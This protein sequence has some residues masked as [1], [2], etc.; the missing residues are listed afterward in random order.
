[1]APP[2][3]P[4]DGAV[5]ETIRTR[6]GTHPLIESVRTDRTGGTISTVCAKL[7][8]DRYPARIQDAEL[9][10]R[11]YTNSDYNFHYL[12]T[13]DAAVWQ[14]RWDRHLNP[15]TQRTHFHPPPEASSADA[16]PDSPGDQHP[17]AIFTRTL[18]NIRERIDDLWEETEL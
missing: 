18:A 11:W 6:A 14:C 16:I 3:A 17:Q 4:I 5:L 2:S 15:H 9:E 7:D 10:I 12:E 13:H 1:M 8:L